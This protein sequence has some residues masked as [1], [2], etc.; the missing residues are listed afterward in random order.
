[1]RR[2]E[3]REIRGLEF[4]KDVRPS[5]SADAE[6]CVRSG[7]KPSDKKGWGLGENASLSAKRSAS[8]L[9]IVFSL[10]TKVNNFPAKH[11]HTHHRR[12]DVSSARASLFLYFSVD[13]SSMKF[14]AFKP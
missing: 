4:S 13:L 10:G 14:S 7:S 5:R 2:S 6:F 1:M 3:N 11:A 8:F 12:N 9:F